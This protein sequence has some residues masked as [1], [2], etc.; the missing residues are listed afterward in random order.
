[1]KCICI[2]VLLSVTLS[3]T[4]G[5]QFTFKELVAMTK[6]QNTFEQNMVKKANFPE[7]KWEE[8]FVQ[9]R[10]R[11]SAVEYIVTSNHFY[12]DTSLVDVTRINILGIIYIE[13]YSSDNGGGSTEYKWVE[14]KIWSEKGT[15]LP[16]RLSRNARSLYVFYNRRNEYLKVLDDINLNAKFIKS[17]K[18][19][20]PDDDNQILLIYKY[21]DVEIEVK[22]PVFSDGGGEIRIILPFK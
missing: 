11:D 16:V 10:K 9:Y 5:Q 1:M 6:S 21:L 22:S 3:P 17:Q 2:A 12:D 8:K 18:S 20:R 19:I 13:N 14:D 15:L 4:F 7:S